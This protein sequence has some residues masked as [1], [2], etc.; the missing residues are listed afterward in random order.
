MKREIIEGASP[1]KM[2]R[3]LLAKHSPVPPS[4]AQSRMELHEALDLILDRAPETVR[5]YVAETL[6]KDAGIYGGTEQATPLDRKR[7][8]VKKRA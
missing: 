2:P 6:T 3:P 7:E 5:A 1:P 8:T 4:D